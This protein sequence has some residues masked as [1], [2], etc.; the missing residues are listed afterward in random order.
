MFAISETHLKFAEQIVKRLVAFCRAGPPL[1][2]L[3]GRFL[4]LVVESPKLK[5]TVTDM[6]SG[7]GLR[8]EPKKKTAGSL[9]SAGILA[10]S[11]VKHAERFLGHGRHRHPQQSFQFGDGSLGFGGRLLMKELAGTI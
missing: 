4:Q 10:G 2:D 7:V 8:S 3:E 1:Q 11:F 9:A 5:A 6:T